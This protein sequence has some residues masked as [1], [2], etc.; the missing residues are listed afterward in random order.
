MYRTVPQ[1][2]A[3]KGVIHSSVGEGEGKPSLLDRRR[4][5]WGGRVGAQRS[6]IQEP[7][8]CEGVASTRL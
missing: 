2:E 3:S 1:M 7:H 4:R 5:W 6:N 8:Q